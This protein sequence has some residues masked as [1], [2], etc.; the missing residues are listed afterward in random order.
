MLEV[1]YA[2]L[3][4]SGI[5]FNKAYPEGKYPHYPEIIPATATHAKPQR[6]CVVCRHRGIRKESRYQCGKCDKGLC[7]APCFEMYHEGDDRLAPQE[8]QE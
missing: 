8:P 4:I 6:K 1:I 5:S 7:P 2:M 3:A